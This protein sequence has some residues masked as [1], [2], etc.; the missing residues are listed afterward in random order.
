MLRASLT[1][2]P[3]D[4]TDEGLESV[5]DRLVGEIGISGLSVWVSSPPA[6]HLRV[7]PVEPR[8]RRTRGGIFFHP[9]AELYQSTRCRPIV[10]SWV[11]TRGRLPQIA[12]AGRERGLELRG[13]VSAALTGRLARRHPQMACKNA[14]SAESHVAVCLANPDVQAYLAGL[15]DDISTKCELG[16]VLVRDFLVTWHEAF[17][18]ALQGPS[19]LGESGQALLATCFCESCYQRATANGVDVVGARRS[20]QVLLQR[21]FE[22]GKPQRQAIETILA[23]D[24]PLA[25]Y[26]QWRANELASLW[27]RL[28]ASCRGDLFL[29]RPV[30]GADH[31]QHESLDLTKP[32]G[33]LTRINHPSQV[34][35]AV[36]TQARQSELG[37]PGALA[38]ASGGA[39]LVTIFSRAAELGFSGV[40]IADYDLLPDTALPAV[41]QA[42]RFARRT[43]TE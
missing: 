18:P 22:R 17:D 6:T 34:A 16:G 14:F 3:W 15:I 2:F 41:R 40:E 36:C 5:L 13:I 38:L 42:I 7:R 9:T 43:T 32:A 12:E 37:V 11:R 35:S 39:E 33:V 21:S 8:V 10:S 29:D 4:L 19:S 20:V 31:R 24:P 28:A 23:D 27:E 25:A 30:A 1:A 26:Y